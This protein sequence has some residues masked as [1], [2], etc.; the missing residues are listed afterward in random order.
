MNTDQIKLVVIKNPFQINK[1]RLIKKI[2]FTGQ[3]IKELIRKFAGRISEPICFVNQKKLDPGL[4][5]KYD[6]QLEGGDEILIM[7]AIRDPVT[8]ATIVATIETMHMAA[9]IAAFLA[10]Y[11]INIAIAYGASYL[12]SKALSEDMD[13][14]GVSAQSYTW[15]GITTQQAGLTIPRAYGRNK[16]YGN[17]I[18]SWTQ[19]TG[20]EETMYMLLSFGKGPFEGIVDGTIQ[21]NDLPYNNYSNV[22]VTE[23]RG[24]INQ[25]AIF[26]GLKIQ[27]EPDKEVIYADGPFTW[28]T[29][30]NDYDSLEIAIEYF[31]FY[32]R[33]SGK[34]GT[35]WVGVKIEISEHGEDFWTTLVDEQLSCS[36]N[37]INFKNY[38]NTETYTGGSP[39]T[40]TNGTRYDIKITSTLAKFAEDDRAQRTV[41][42]H[43]V[44]EVIDTAF[45]FPNLTLLGIEALASDQVSGSM[46]VSCE[47][48][49]RII[50]VYDGMS[51]NLEYSNNPAWVIWDILTQP[52]ISGDGDPDLPTTPYAIER[53][54]GYDPARL[55]PY[56]DHWYE[57]AQ[58]Y[59]GLVDD[60]A[61]GTEKRIT[62][63]GVFDQGMNVWDAVKKVCAMARCQVVMVGRDFD[64]VVDKPWSGPSVQLFSAGNIKPQTFKLNYME[65]E[66]RASEIE[67]NFLNSEQDFEETPLLYYD[68][69]IGCPNKKI[70]VNGFGITKA[71]Q[72]WRTLYYE[73]AR[74]RLINLSSEHESD[75][76]A[77]VSV[78]GDVVSLMP[79]WKRGGR[80]V[81]CPANNQVIVDSPCMDTGTDTIVVRVCDPDTGG[82]SIEIHTVSSVNGTLITITDTWTI[83]PKKGDLYDFGP[84]SDATKM[85][86]ITGINEGGDFS[87]TISCEIYDEDVYGGDDLE[88]DTP[89]SSYIVPSSSSPSSRT[90]PITSG[91]IDKFNLDEFY[92]GEN[93]DFPIIT[94][95]AWG[96]NDPST[97]YVSWSKDDS[98]E[99]ILICLNNI[100]YE[101]TESNSANIYIYWDEASPTVLH[102]TDV[103]NET[104][105][106]GKWLIC[107]NEN[108]YANP[109]YPFKTIHGA[110]VKAE[111]IIDKIITHNGEIVVHNGNVVCIS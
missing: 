102:E 89:E 80:I 93:Y 32:I 76:D 64:I 94:N 8:T 57:A 43:S 33:K 14:E 17:I 36:N 60:G 100:S 18:A 35:Q 58:H 96:N 109:N 92:E 15:A 29:P 48:E 20:Y 61:G 110:A 81:G 37:K 49:C 23:Q 101:I 72:A 19:P 75:L 65:T 107:I 3:N 40:V 53:Y 45:Q 62:F 7:P 34:N 9:E 56:L 38:L 106:S 90:R 22:T 98:E 87:R 25:D 28:T 83:N 4:G 67:I 11:A 13:V 111:S 63:N 70:T 21:I 78:K 41:K 24:L 82:D 91:E 52:V 99:D 26:E 1:N 97:G 42:L 55:L 105:G 69:N 104:T 2:R 88:P 54:D 30:D 44:R 51:W 31:G 73:M 46:K 6:C 27:Y 86:R 68:S 5:E 66:D 16:M 79:P 47:Q 71:S 59:D 39:V 77:I 12:V 95:L 103:L 10:P 85:F 50:N 108:G 84:T 74:N